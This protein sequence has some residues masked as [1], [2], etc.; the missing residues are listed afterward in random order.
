VSE[1]NNSPSHSRG[2]TRD[3]ENNEP[4]EEENKHVSRPNSWIHEPF[5]IPIH[6]R[7]WNRFH[8]QIRHFFFDRIGSDRIE[9]RLLLIKILY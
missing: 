4:T 3:R 2:T 1:I 7:W 6:I 5:R 8:I 9:S